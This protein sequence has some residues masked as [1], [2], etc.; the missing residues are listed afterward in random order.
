MMPRLSALTSMAVLVGMLVCVPLLGA[1][2]TDGDQAGLE[3]KLEA[4]QVE[5]EALSSELAGYEQQVAESIEALETAA[6][7]GRKQELRR[8]ISRVEDLARRR[9][10][11]DAQLAGLEQQLGDMSETSPTGQSIPV[12][13]YDLYGV[14]V[15][16]P[17]RHQ[18]FYARVD[19]GDLPAQSEVLSADWH[20]ERPAG[21]AV[22]RTVSGA[23]GLEWPLESNEAS[24]LGHYDVSVNLQTDM[25]AFNGSAGFDLIDPEDEEDEDEND[26]VKPDEDALAMEASVDTPVYTGRPS[27][28]RV[29]A[30]PFEVA[31][32]SLLS[33]SGLGAYSGG[34]FWRFDPNARQVYFRPK[35]PGAQTP[36][37]MLTYK[38]QQAV[39]EFSCDVELT[40]LDVTVL[41]DRTDL[42]RLIIPFEIVFPDYLEASFSLRP[43]GA[44]AIR[45][46]GAPSAISGGGHILRGQLN[47]EWMLPGK[48]YKYD[49]SDATGAEAVAEFDMEVQT[50]EIQLP[51]KMPPADK[52]IP[53]ETPQF[54]A[55]ARRLAGFEAD[56]IWATPNVRIVR[57][58]ADYRFWLMTDEERGGDP[59]DQVV[60]IAAVGEQGLAKASKHLEIDCVCCEVPSRVARAIRTMKNPWALIAKVRAAAADEDEA[61]MQRLARGY[62]L[63]LAEFFNWM[64]GLDECRHLT[65][66]ARVYFSSMGRL[67]ELAV[68]EEPP[69]DEVHRLMHQL[70]TPPGP[71]AI[72]PGFMCGEFEDIAQGLSGR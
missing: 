54:R 6:R 48:R 36:R 26:P 38:G 51:R 12:A 53:L 7:E 59:T 57:S 25:G 33:F 49:V 37:F 39:G 11:L 35:Q 67:F 9:E 24:P 14:P 58:G 10:V 19:R 5:Y 21:G 69:E 40:R 72:K 45:A 32:P 2:T 31:D 18:P 50:F 23:A 22:N 60:R 65:R 66:Q 34:E 15:S 8:L 27:L 55:L 56:R 71:S 46:S 68:M 62:A 41:L 13:L 44:R 52:D 20:L 4:L 64:G 30:L 42:E 17:V 43:N 16:S 1:E 28:V 47:A 61:R 3:A 63:D 29:H 70:R